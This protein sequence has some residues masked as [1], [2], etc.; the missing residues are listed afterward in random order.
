[1]NLYTNLLLKITR[2]LLLLKLKSLSNFD[3]TPEAAV[4]RCS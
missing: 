4:Q 1:M 3:I 2:L